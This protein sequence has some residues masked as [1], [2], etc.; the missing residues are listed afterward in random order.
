MRGANEGWARRSV[1]AGA[2]VFSKQ[3]A[4]QPPRVESWRT[5]T[6][7]EPVGCADHGPAGWQVSQP[8]RSFPPPGGHVMS[9]EETTGL[10]A[11]ERAAPI[12]PLQPGWG[13]RPAYDDIRPG[14]QGLL[15]HGNGAPG[16]RI[17][18]S[19]GAPSTEEDCAAPS[20][21]TRA[22]APEAPGLVIGEQRTSHHAATCGR[23]VARAGRIEDEWGAQ[24]KRGVGKSRQTRAACLREV[25][26]RL[27]L[28]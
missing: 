20:A 5:A 3:A 8:A 25:R 4:W 10:Q 27:R 9:P 2:G 14:P 17:A 19:M 26:H 11:L 13:A 12:V 24:E 23:L 7:A 28:L 16:A 21:P 18:P 22:T 1:P 6:P 15:A